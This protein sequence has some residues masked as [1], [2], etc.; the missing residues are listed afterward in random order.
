[1]P[2][3][4]LEFNLPA[5][6]PKTLPIIPL[7]GT[8]LLPGALAPFP[9]GRKS[10]MLAVRNADEKLVIVARQRD[11]DLESPEPD[12]LYPIATLGK[13][14]NER[15]GRGGVRIVMVQGLRRVRFTAFD[16]SAPYMTASFEMIEEPWPDSIETEALARAFREA[17]GDAAETLGVD[18]DYEV[19]TRSVP[20]VSMLVD[21]VASLLEAPEEWFAE[22]LQ[23]VEPVE[24]AERVLK[25]L[26]TV[27]DVISAQKSIQDKMAEEAQQMNREHILRRQ[28]KAIQEELGEEADDDL[29]QLKEKLDEADL[30]DQVREAVGRELK[31]LDRL[32]AQSPERSVAIDWLEWVAD[33]PWNVHGAES[34]DLYA[35]EE[36]LENSHY[37]LEDVKKQVIQHLAVRILAGSGRADVLLL[38]GPPGVGKTSIAQS[39]ADATGR[40]LVRIA[41][42]GVRDEAELRGHRRTYIGARPGR[43]IEGIRRAGSADPVVILDE[44]DKLAQGYQGDPAAALLEILD[45]EQNHSFTDH[46]M[47]VPFDLSKALFVATANDVSPIRGPLRDRMEVIEIAGYTRAEKVVIARKHLLEKLAKNAG[48]EVADV[49]FDDDVIAAVVEGWTRE[50]GVRQL[51]RA[52]GKIYRAAAVQKARG[53]LNESLVVTTDDLKEYLGRVKF[54]KDE[55]DLGSQPGIATGL[56]WT[57]AGGEVLYI[58]TTTMAGNGKLVLTGQLGDVMKESAQAALT[59]IKAHADRIGIPLD[60]FERRDIHIH[61]PAGAVPK[62]GPSAGVTMF[63]A[64]AS[65][66]SGRPVRSDVAMTGEATL[67]GRVLPVGGIK[68]KV[69]AAHRN[70]ITRIV[71]PR[72]NQHD[73]E[74]VP[75]EAHADL[76]FILVDDMDEVLDHVL[77]PVDP[78][79]ELGATVTALEGWAEKIAVGG[80]PPA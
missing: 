22:I 11:T 74:D 75:D 25:R 45:P 4:A 35:I 70:G 57:P 80:M 32:S 18:D 17:L 29:I 10:T 48:L 49:T 26:L 50:A 33:L 61:I 72:R 5:D 27:K 53:E 40:E 34:D 24:R 3:L 6:I 14:V 65:L 73:L 30:P 66:L 69:L 62:D 59:Y 71:L 54:H 20:S 13:V 76:E 8:V 16:T 47:E 9:I 43:I 55:H 21:A 1:M 38:V 64:L 37:G 52:I 56:A 46:Y 58:E 15:I 41:L 60:A 77:E 36:T 7:R 44:V 31:R 2:M 39:I 67:R 23:L 19:L 63:T 42:G 79:T 51:Q 28:L 68:S 12:D 78:A